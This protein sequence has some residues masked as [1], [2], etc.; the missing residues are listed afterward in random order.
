MVVGTTIFSIRAI[1]CFV[2]NAHP[3]LDEKVDRIRRNTIFGDIDGYL[4]LYEYLILFSIFCIQAA[5]FIRVFLLNVI[6]TRFVIAD[7]KNIEGRNITEV[8]KL[9]DQ[10]FGECSQFNLEIWKGS[11]SQFQGRSK[12]KSSY[13]NG[14]F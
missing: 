2:L 13:G 6:G 7:E 5:S 4:S 11:L 12:K 10:S 1:D 8:M 14:Y 3:L 9:G